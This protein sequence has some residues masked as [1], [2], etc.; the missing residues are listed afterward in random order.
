MVVGFSDTAS[1][2]PGVTHIGGIVPGWR[3]QKQVA[4]RAECGAEGWLRRSQVSSSWPLGSNGWEKPE[5][6]PEGLSK[7][8]ERE[9][10]GYGE[11]QPAE[12]VLGIWSG[13]CLEDS[14]VGSTP[15][16]GLRMAV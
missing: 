16:E 12:G 1:S 3:W 5:R 7:R 14:T 6:T 15:R 10:W 11:P 13:W 4:V 8:A 9:A 2:R